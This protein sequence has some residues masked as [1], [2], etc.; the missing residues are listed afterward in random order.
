M[1]V[2]NSSGT[3]EP[4]GYMGFRTV[5]KSC[6]GSTVTFPSLQW[7]LKILLDPK[8]LLPQEL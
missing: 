5:S 2:R 4:Q 6:V 7:I 3:A 1:R 8:Y